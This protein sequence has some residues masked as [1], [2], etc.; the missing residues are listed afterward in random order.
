MPVP[1]T[2]LQAKPGAPAPL[3][4]TTG[5]PGNDLLSGSDGNDSLAGLAGNDTLVGSD[6]VDT[7]DHGPVGLFISVDLT[8]GQAV[9]TYTEEGDRYVHT[10]SLIENFVCGDGDGITLIGSAGNNLLV[11]GRTFESL[12]VGNAGADTLFGNAGN[13]TLRC[14]AGNDTLDGGSGTGDFAVHRHDELA[15]TSGRVLSLAAL[16]TASTVTVTDERGGTDTLIAAM[17]LA[18]DDSWLPHPPT[19][20]AANIFVT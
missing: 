3:F 19:L 2:T 4:T 7:V 1:H 5:T 16:G 14:D 8:Q 18:A 10:L 12:L 9:Q 11:S 17:P 13:D 6:G 20:T 15:V